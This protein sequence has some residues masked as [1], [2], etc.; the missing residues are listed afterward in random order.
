MVVSV[1]FDDLLLVQSNCYFGLLSMDYTV[2]NAS[3]KKGIFLEYIEFDCEYCLRA[4]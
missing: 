1:R 3:K 2:N 4:V